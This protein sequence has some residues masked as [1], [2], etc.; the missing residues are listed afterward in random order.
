[1]ID[2]TDGASGASQLRG[3]ASRGGSARKG[4]AGGRGRVSPQGA[5]G[6]PGA[7]QPE[8]G[9]RPLHGE[10]ARKG[11][12]AGRVSPGGAGGVAAGESDWE[13]RVGLGGAA[14]PTG[15]SAGR[16]RGGRVPPGAVPGPGTVPPRP[17]QHRG[18]LVQRIHR[19]ALS[20]ASQYG[21]AAAMPPASGR[22]CSLLVR[23]LTQMMRCATRDSRCISRRSTA[24][25]PVS[26]PSEMITTTAPRARPGRP[27][28]SLN[29]FSEAPM[30]VPPSQ[31][32]AAWPPAAG[33]AR[34]ACAPAPRSAG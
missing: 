2:V 4:R 33:P 19:C 31:S 12:A 7:G 25:S 32:G 1:M 16:G 18:Q 11:R 27:T 9:G 34:A 5:G 15:Q 26:Q 6:R 3:A 29:S 23:G 28:V 21:H 14:G 30:R 8:R 24:G 22:Y 13:G 10:S 17:G 20:T